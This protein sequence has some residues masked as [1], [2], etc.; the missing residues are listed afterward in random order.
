[1]EHPLRAHGCLGVAAG[2]EIAAQCMAV[3]GTLTA[4]APD[5]ATLTATARSATPSAG[6][7]AGLRAV[8]FYVERL[9][10]IV[11]DLIA[12]VQCRGSNAMM[13]V[14][15]FSLTGGTRLLV[16]GRATIVSSTPVRS[17]SVRSAT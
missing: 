16:A 4:C 7:L 10:L 6:Y 11:E 1:M 13:A 3:H 14:Y 15:D 9:D 12:T 2:I 5:A 17:S 8:T